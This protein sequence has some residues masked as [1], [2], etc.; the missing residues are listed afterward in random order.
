MVKLW[1]GDWYR[2]M[3]F[4]DVNGLIWFCWEHLQKTYIF[5]P[6]TTRLFKKRPAGIWEMDGNGYVL[7]TWNDGHW[8]DSNHFPI[9]LETFLGKHRKIY[10]DMWLSPTR[11]SGG[12][13]PMLEAKS[14]LNLLYPSVL[15]GCLG[16]SESGVPLKINWLMINARIKWPK[17]GIYSIFRPTYYIINI[18]L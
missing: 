6:P 5:F 3:V 13:L 18:W 11:T 17:Q 12:F 7:G 14:L 1:Q 16:L 2:L 8:S 4:L 10:R 9:N 15:N